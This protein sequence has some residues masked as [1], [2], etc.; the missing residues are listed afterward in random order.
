M[1][2]PDLSHDV[3]GPITQRTLRQFGGFWFLF[4]G[5]LASWQW[6]VRGHQALALVL[7]GVGAVIG[8]LGLLRPEAMRPLF[9]GLV[10]LTFPIGWV[11]SHL[12][13][14]ILLYGIFTPV[15]VFFRLIGRDALSV[16][17]HGERETYWVR[18]PTASDVRSYL[19]QS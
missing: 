16:R 6:F 8:S 11:V 10:V 1:I 5:A 2:E 9:A 12:L 7:I 17:P 19:R 18:K 4:F 3:A 13:L 15:A 14:A